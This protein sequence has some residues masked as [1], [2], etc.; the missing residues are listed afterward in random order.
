MRFEGEAKQSKVKT[1]IKMDE[2]VLDIHSTVLTHEIVEA[3]SYLL[4]QWDVEV[5][6]FGA[7]R[8][9]LHFVVCSL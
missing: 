9:L 6:R 1:K 8:W 5:E 2:A 4:W 3:C 7:Q